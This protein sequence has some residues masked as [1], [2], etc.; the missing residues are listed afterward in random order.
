MEEDDHE[1]RTD[2]RCGSDSTSALAEQPAPRRLRVGRGAERG[3]LCNL[4]FCSASFKKQ[5]LDGDS[6]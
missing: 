5:E 2:H 6:S 4:T 3:H 1:S